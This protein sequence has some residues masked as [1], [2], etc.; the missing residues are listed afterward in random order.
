MLLGSACYLGGLFVAFLGAGPGNG[1]GLIVPIGWHVVL[2]VVAVLVIVDSIRKF[3]ARKTE[4]LAT[5]LLVVKLASIPFFLINFAV[6]AWVVFFGSA[7]AALSEALVEAAGS[8]LLLVAI[9]VGLTYL[10]MLTTSTYGWAAIAA[11]RRDGRIGTPL[12][13]LYRLLLLVFVADILVGV[14]VHWHSRR[15]ESSTAAVNPGRPI[16]RFVQAG[17]LLLGTLMYALVIAFAGQLS[18]AYTLYLN[19]FIVGFW[20][21][22]LLVVTGVVIVDAVRK[23]RAGRTQEL[24]T[25]TLLVKLAAIPF[26]L[27]NFVVLAVLAIGG[28]AIFI[29]GGIAL[30]FAVWIGIGLTY[31]TMLSTSVY[32]WA[33]IARLRREKT[34]GS[35]LSV[36]YTFLTLGF[37]TD[38]AAGILLFGHARRRA[39]L[40]LTIVLI[41]T[42]AILAAPR[43]LIDYVQLPPTADFQDMKL[44]LAW[45]SVSGMALIVGTIIVALT[46]WVVVRRRRRTATAIEGSVSESAPVPVEQ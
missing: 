10:A 20:N 25:G 9:T 8:V 29:F 14:L 2:L 43:F 37:L 5:D 11:L 17:T 40:A 13:V 45:I 1:L 16:V 38:T 46:R 22:L 12:A 44:T 36:L 6:L 34:I 28:L 19:F 27:L 35:G 15:G 4:Q 18:S 3:R 41:T 23:V 24:A 7:I 42:G 21:T 30:L 33:T 26:F 32:A 39:G 31:L